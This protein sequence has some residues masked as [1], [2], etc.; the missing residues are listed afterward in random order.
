MAALVGGWFLDTGFGLWADLLFAPAVGGLLLLASIAL[1][2][3]LLTIARKLPRLAAGFVVGSLLVVVLVGG[4]A[5]LIVGPILVLIGG[6][7]GATVATFL[8]GV[9]AGAAT[10]KK[11]VAI[12]LF[13]LSLASA[14]WVIVFLSNDG[15]LE[16]QLKAQLRSPA[17]APLN[18]ENPGEPGPFK[19][20]VITYGAKGGNPRRPEYDN[21]T[22]A[23]PATDASRFFKDFKGWKRSLRKA[24]WGYG[25]DRLPLN[26]TVWLPDGPGPFPLVLIVHGNH[27]MAEFSDPGYRYLGELLA[28]RG[29]ILASIDENFLNS[30]LFHDPPKQQAV[31]G[32]LLL[33]HLKLWRAWSADPGNPMGVAIDFDRIA[34]VGHSRGGEAV[35]T[36]ALFNRMSHYPDDA[37]ILFDYQFPIRSLVAIAP[38]DGQ[39]RPAGQWRALENVSYLTIQGANDADVSSFEGSRQ[40]ERVTFTDGGDW[41]K[42]ELYVYRANHG[43]FNTVWGR[44]DAG[45]PL[46][47][48]LNLKPLLGGE[49]QR[50]IGRVY[51]SAFLEATLHDRREYLPLFRDY[52]TIGSWLPET[53][54]M[55]RY[56]DAAFRLVADFN[57]D[58]D[59][60]TTTLAGG[61]I[62]GTDL[63]VW[64]EGRIPF[65]EG[66]RGTNGVFLGWNRRNVDDRDDPGIR[67]AYSITLPDGAAASWNLSGRSALVLSIAALD[68]KVPRLD[69]AR[70]GKDD[71]A[72]KDKKRKKK[73]DD[74][75]SIKDPE[76]PDFSVELAAADGA[77]ATHALTE[78]GTILPPFKVRFTKIEMLDGIGFE[79]PYEATFQTIRIPLSAFQGVDP[80]KLST[81][82]LRFDRIPSSLILL[83]KVG[84]E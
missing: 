55:N 36:A 63:S 50:R 2:P 24:Y 59:V 66:D 43:Q 80:S 46:G 82:R 12:G 34:L 79:K 49:D 33:E 64:R 10:R 32:W 22:V 60:S 83:S 74:G 40:W 47:W 9:L 48:I 29:F 72:K 16:G 45:Y 75:D 15:T 17:P 23:T 8:S 37:S 18:T 31:R 44:S 69:E 58:P 65:R 56:Q 30:G 70:G 28:S 81:I 38:V 35:A 25:M 13:A 78:F 71:G 76:P 20:R 6:V 7:M 3:L 21:P 67:P 54:Y 73:S 62:D 57:E 39:Y 42:S 68:D 61:R 1:V 5:G 14:I 4:P 19:T 27:N 51:I 84:F 41:F 77:T 11:I 52:R 53:L 26:A